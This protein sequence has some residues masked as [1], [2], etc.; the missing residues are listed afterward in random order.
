MSAW[1]IKL[2]ALCP[3]AADGI[4][5]LS[6]SGAS[7]AAR[8]D[9][10]AVTL[11]LAIAEAARRITAARR[12]VIAGMGGDVQ[13]ARAALSLGDR[14]G[15]RLLHRNQFVAQRNLF[16]QQSRGAMTTT[17]AEVKQR[18]EMVV[19]VGSDVTR[20]FPRLLE[21]MFMPNPVFVAVEARRLVLLGAPLPQRLPAPVAVDSVDCGGLDLFESV[22]V[23]RARLRRQPLPEGAG[24][25]EGLTD[26]ARRMADCRYGVIVWAAGDL[27][28]DGADLLIEQMHQLVIDLNRQTRWAA[29]PLGG[30]D[31]DLSANAVA[32]WQ[33]GFPLPIEFAAG[34]VAYDPFPDY[35]DAD[36]L[37]WLGALPG[38]GAAELPGVA[39]T[40]PQI[41]IGAPS[42][43]VNLPPQHVFIP[44]AT[45]GVS[46]SGHLVRTDGVITLYAPA[47]RASSL[48]PAGVVIDAIAA[49]ATGAAS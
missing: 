34:R 39:A 43:G 44:V 48:P 36:L 8:I 5:G 13:A 10:V 23:L 7:D 38:V 33:T 3:R 1:G 12:P 47:V 26:L 28:M 17:L 30:N 9:G 32:T 11:D 29:L 18:A 14:V 24:A 25:L 37:L 42:R 2:Q 22:A 4:T 15:A 21:R 45:P 46:A 16:A 49:A 20:S 27:N 31:G 40:T 35:S 41:V 6:G 19:I